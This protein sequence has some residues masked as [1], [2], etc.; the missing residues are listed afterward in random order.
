MVSHQETGSVTADSN[1]DHPFTCKAPKKDTS[2]HSQAPTRCCNTPAAGAFLAL[3]ILFFKDS[4]GVEDA[5]HSS[6]MVA[7][8][9]QQLQGSRGL[10]AVLMIVGVLLILYGESLARCAGPAV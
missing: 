1:G 5:P 7:N 8:A 10:R 9:L 6:S 3:A 4:G 2:L